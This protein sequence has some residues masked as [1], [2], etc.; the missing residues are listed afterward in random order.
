MQPRLIDACRSARAEGATTS[1]SRSP[2][3]RRWPRAT[4]TDAVTAPTRAMHMT[5]RATAT[6][7]PVVVPG[8]S[9]RSRPGATVVV[10]DQSGSAKLL[11]FASGWP[12]SASSTAIAPSP[13]GIRA[14]PPTPGRRKSNGGARL[15][16]LA[17]SRT[18]RPGRRCDRRPV[19]LLL[20]GCD[21][22]GR[23]DKAIHTPAA[24]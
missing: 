15:G 13:V 24:C 18:V 8:S 23:R 17:L 4:A 16:P 14:A 9:R 1:S 7:R 20:K 19:R 11:M 22:N 21:R 12:C 3:A 10:A 2:V 6:R 5:M